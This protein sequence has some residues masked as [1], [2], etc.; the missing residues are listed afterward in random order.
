MIRQAKRPKTIH[1]IRRKFNIDVEKNDHNFFTINVQND[2]LMCVLKTFNIKLQFCPQQ[3]SSVTD[4]QTL[5][6]NS[7]P[8]VPRWN[9]EP[10]WRWSRAFISRFLYK[11]QNKHTNK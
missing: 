7:V 8:A 5:P 2:K 6:V 3:F 4:A 10:V 9:I 1:S 11:N